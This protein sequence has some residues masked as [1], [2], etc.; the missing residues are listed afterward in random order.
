MSITFPQ[1]PL[2][3]YILDNIYTYYYQVWSA[4]DQCLPSHEINNKAFGE[5]FEKEGEFGDISVQTALDHHL[6]K[7]KAST[8]DSPRL[9]PR[10]P[11][12]GLFL[13]Y[14]AFG[15]ETERMKS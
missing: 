6:M 9:W 1:P 13:S 12:F 4:Y 15:G 3:V 5:I 14:F 11:F 8:G 7:M 10:I 2:C